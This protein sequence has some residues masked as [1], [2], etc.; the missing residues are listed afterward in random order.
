[1]LDAYDASI[2]SVG[3]APAELFGAA[4][5]ALRAGGA[6]ACNV[7]GT[8]REYG[9]V[10][11]AVAAARSVFDDVRILPVLDPDE[12][13]SPDSLRNVV[14]VATNERLASAH[15]AGV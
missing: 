12:R 13:F 9:P 1:V 5:R 14:I 6:L 8:L 2:V 7:I 4:C 11:N 15:G 10:A 3:T